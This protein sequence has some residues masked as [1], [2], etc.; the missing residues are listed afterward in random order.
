MPGG[1]GHLKPLLSLHPGL[2]I[3]HN[4]TNLFYA[5]EFV[6]ATGNKF[7]A[8]EV[9]QQAG[10]PLERCLEMILSHQI[11]DNLS[12]VACSPITL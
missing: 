6:E 11:V 12:I 8:H 5:D 1:D 4:T 10:V 7:H 9:V 2:D 3:V